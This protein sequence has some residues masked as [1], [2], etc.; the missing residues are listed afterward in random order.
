MSVVESVLHTLSILGFPSIFA[1]GGY[2]VLISK[3]VR[4][5]MKAQQADMRHQLLADY[6]K[7]IDRGYITDDEQEDWESRYQAYHSLGQNGVLDAKRQELF[8]LPNRP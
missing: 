7:Y 5:L 2:V 4:I 8:E 6:H 1:I 3:R